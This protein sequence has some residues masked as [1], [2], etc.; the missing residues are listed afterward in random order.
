MRAGYNYR[1]SEMHAALMVGQVERLDGNLARRREIA[2]RYGTEIR[3][4]YVALP[5]TSAGAEPVWQTY[6]VLA[7]SASSRRDLEA[8]LH[9]RRIASAAG[10]QCIPNEP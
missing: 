7:R 4:P 6:H 9:S 10:A 3:N 1:L 5:G 2:H 8:H